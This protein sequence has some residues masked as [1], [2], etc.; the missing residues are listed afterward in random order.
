MIQKIFNEPTKPA[1]SPSS[2]NVPIPLP[3]ML[4]FPMVK[5]GVND[6]LYL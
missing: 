6:S 1:I 4:M 3:A 5:S 2:V